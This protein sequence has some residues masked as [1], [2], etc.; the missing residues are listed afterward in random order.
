MNQTGPSIALIG[1]PGLVEPLRFAGY[2]LLA[3]G[4]T[5]AAT[6]AKAAKHAAAE[7]QPYVVLSAPPDL[8]VRAWV[9]IQVAQRR[10]VLHLS[11]SAMPMTG[12]P[13]PGTRTVSLPATLDE[14]MGIFGAPPVGGAAGTVTITE[15]GALLSSPTSAPGEDDPFTAPW[16]GQ[17]AT[18]PYETPVRVVPPSYPTQPPDS[19]PASNEFTTSPPPPAPVSSP[20]TYTPPPEPG[21]TQPQ[22]PSPVAPMPHTPA[23]TAWAPPLGAAPG[24]RPPGT[25]APV[26]ISFAAKGGVGKTTAASA[27]AQR[28][29]QVGGIRKVVLIDMNRGQGDIRKNLRLDRP[30]RSI[31]DAALAGEPKSAVISPRRLAEARHPSLPKLGFGVV[32]APQDDQAD[33]SVVTTQV[34]RDVIDYA[35]STSDLVIVDTQII[36]GTDTSGLIDGIVVPVLSRDGWGLALSDTSMTGVDNLLKRLRMWSVAGVSRD[37]MLFALNR[38]NADSGLN[39]EVLRRIY[40]GL[41]V[42]IGTIPQDGMLAAGFETG[43]LPHNHPDMARVLDEVLFRVTGLE[44]F[45]PANHPPLGRKP[46]GGGLLRRRKG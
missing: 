5:D 28:A 46:R 15:H 27:L 38:A 4:A 18:N 22:L 12:D 43:Q 29:V 16:P 41:A 13:I 6:V 36:E 24:G 35:R 34:Y 1:L 17:P 32:L 3:D 44:A 11:S 20:V 10:R 39:T 26:I 2:Q 31:Y 14:I 25:K 42:P 23:A 40:S 8:R 45:D 9:G 37:R 21:P 7:A 19:A 33:P 30:L